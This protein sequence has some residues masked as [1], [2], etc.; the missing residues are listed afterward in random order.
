MKI[1]ML[2]NNTVTDGG[3]NQ[4]MAESMERSKKELG[5]KDDQVIIVESLPDGSTE[6]D[7]T[8]V[9]LSVHPPALLSMSTLRRSSTPMFTSPSLKVCLLT[10]IAPSPAGTSKQSSCVAMQLP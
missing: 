4:A 6:A 2:L 8:I 1:G 9:Q 7:S 10:T 3:W 5:L